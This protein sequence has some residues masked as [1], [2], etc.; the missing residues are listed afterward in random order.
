MNVHLESGVAKKY[1]N[2]F[3]SVG[4]L[5]H[6]HISKKENQKRIL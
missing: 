5:K 6:T 1:R 2:A 3:T 4:S